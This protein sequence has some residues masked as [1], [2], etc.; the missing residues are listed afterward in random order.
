MSGAPGV[1]A[2]DV[3]QARVRRS[4]FAASSHLGYSTLAAVCATNQGG[5]LAT[6]PPTYCEGPA[7]LPVGSAVLIIGALLNDRS[8]AEIT[9]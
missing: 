7:M 4:A 8:Y 3:A 6:L 5:A 1:R 2:G 9:A